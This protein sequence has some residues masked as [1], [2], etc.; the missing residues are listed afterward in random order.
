MNLNYLFKSVYDMF[1]D[2]IIWSDMWKLTTFLTNLEYAHEH[3]ISLIKFVMTINTIHSYFTFCK[4]NIF[5]L[6]MQYISLLGFQAHPLLLIIIIIFLS[7]LML[8]RSVL[9]RLSNL[10]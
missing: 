3:F 6:C 8:V 9:A 4:K 2:I 10:S 7:I 5:G 1:F